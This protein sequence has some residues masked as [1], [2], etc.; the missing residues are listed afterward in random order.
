[1][2]KNEEQKPLVSTPT[3][4]YGTNIKFGINA[5]TSFEPEI[6]PEKPIVVQNT[7]VPETVEDFMRMIAEKH[8]KQSFE[9]DKVVDILKGKIIYMDV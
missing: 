3:A 6:V 8:G 4:T 7:K 2:L 1:M 9:Y 5:S